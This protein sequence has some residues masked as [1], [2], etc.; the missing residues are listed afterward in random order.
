[1]HQEGFG[2]EH[3]AQVELPGRE[4][5][6]FCCAG[7]SGADFVMVVSVSLCSEIALCLAAI[8]HY[9]LLS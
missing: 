7:V 8:F 9:L 1:M 5:R 3:S 4:R 2:V 6:R